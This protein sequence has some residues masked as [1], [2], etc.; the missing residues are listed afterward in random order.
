[1]PLPHPSAITFDTI[2]HGAAAEKFQAELM[3]VLANIAD[4]NTPALKKRT[5]NIKLAFA[6]NTDRSEAIITVDSNSTL[7]ASQTCDSHVF[8]GRHKGALVAIEHNPN[9]LGLFEE[10]SGPVAVSFAATPKE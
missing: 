2:A 8:L 4:P 5:I 9:Q 6:P 1:M 10:K 7:V 3:R